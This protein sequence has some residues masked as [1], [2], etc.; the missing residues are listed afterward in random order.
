M[1]IDR[2]SYLV[3]V[4]SCPQSLHSTAPNSYQGVLLDE[5]FFFCLFVFPIDFFLS[6]GVKSG[7]INQLYFTS[8][9]KDTL[10]KL[11]YQHFFY[12]RTVGCSSS[13]IYFSANW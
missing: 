13:L 7:K 1:K 4:A 10:H 12:P 3:C 2:T 5:C 11:R 6:G 9:D 8:S